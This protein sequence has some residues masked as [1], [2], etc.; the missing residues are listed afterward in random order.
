MYPLPEQGLPSRFCKLCIGNSLKIIIHEY[1]L[2]PSAV[3]HTPRKKVSLH[4][5]LPMYQ[6][7]RAV[8]FCVQ[9]GLHPFTFPAYKRFA[10]ISLSGCH[11]PETNTSLGIIV[12][13]FQQS[14]KF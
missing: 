4:T 5:K 10:K 7:L 6:D 1:S 11:R 13:P 8:S 2:F 9:M 14:V 3:E 12:Y